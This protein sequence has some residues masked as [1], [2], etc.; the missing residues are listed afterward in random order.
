M[1]K[2][3][4]FLQRAAFFDID[5]TLTSENVWRGIMAYFETH[6]LR[7][8]TLWFFLLTHMPLVAFRKLGLI[9]ELG[10]RTPWAANLAWLVR[11]MTIA[12]ANAIWD[13]VAEEFL[14]RNN[15][16]RPDSCRLVGHHL[17]EQDVV[18][19]VSSGPEPL[20]AR[21]AEGM[22]VAH[23]VG[24]RLEIGPDGHFTGRS[25]APVCIDRH[26]ASLAR[27]R[28]ADLGLEVDYQ[29]SFSY[30]DSIT[31][32]AMLEMVGRPV[33]VYPEPALRDIAVQRGWE[34]FV[35]NDD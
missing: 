29:D 8:G 2:E 22:G 7:R 20:I 16:W 26:K 31:D 30:A 27:Q 15:Y 18:M 28:L 33:A 34:I 17:A 11:G 3:D 25:L 5:G 12:E 14:D 1:F 10:L 23:A 24:T 6:N 4:F 19:L 21:L 35:R 32:L 13:W 9:S